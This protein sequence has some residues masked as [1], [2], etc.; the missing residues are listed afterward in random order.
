M[1]RAVTFDYWNTL[2]YEERGH[3]RG[4]RAAAWA[5]ILEGAGFAAEREA[6]GAVFDATWAVAAEHWVT[7]DH[8]SSEQAAEIAVEKLGFDVPADIRALLIEAF[9][10]AGK[11]AE[12]HLTDGL[13]EC[14]ALLKDRGVKIGI[15]CDVGFTPSRILRAFL[16]ARGLLRNFDSWAFSDDVG[17]YKPARK[18]FEHALTPLG[19]APEHAAHVGDLRRTDITGARAMGMTAVRYT[20][21]WEDDSQLEPEGHFVIS[22]HAELP[23]VL[24]LA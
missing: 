24:G 16:E 21:V 23:G 4:K 3:L 1:I 5:G 20:G 10:D 12:L 8:L 7:N 6:L 18:I 14:I 15:V 22:K 2:V 19:V 11:D 13:E 17:V 9:S